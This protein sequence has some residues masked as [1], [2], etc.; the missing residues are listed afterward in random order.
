M[1]ATTSI[2][3]RSIVNMTIAA[4]SRARTRRSSVVIARFP[5]PRCRP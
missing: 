1:S 5:T 3:G 2:R 4:A